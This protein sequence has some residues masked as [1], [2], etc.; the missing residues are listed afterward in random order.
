MPTLAQVRDFVDNRLAN[1]F[2]NQIVPRENTYF[3]AHGRYFQGLAVINVDTELPNNPNSGSATVLEVTLNAN[4]KPTDQAESWSDLGFNFGGTTLPMAILIDAYNGPGGHGYVTTVYARWNGNW[5][6][7]SHN[8]GPEDWRTKA[9][10]Q[11]SRN[12]LT[13][14]TGGGNIV[15]PATGRMAAAWSTVK[16]WFGF[17]S[18]IEQA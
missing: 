10:R 11:V 9:W 17:G 1:F 8:V 13:G 14:D 2:T 4:V 5:Y 6:S 7:R 18:N 16:S 15:P 3:A 12:G